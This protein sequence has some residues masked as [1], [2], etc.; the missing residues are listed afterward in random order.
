MP[1]SK[2]AWKIAAATLL[3]LCAGGFAAW[4]FTNPRISDERQIQNLVAKVEHGVETKSG[5]E[6]MECVAP[7]YQDSS[8]FDRLEVLKL[9][10]SWVRSPEQ[11][12]VVV[13]EYQIEVEGRNAI[14]HFDVQVEVQEGER[15]R[16]PL[17]MEFEVKFE[18][19]WRKLRRVWL[20]KAVEGPSLRAAPE[21]YL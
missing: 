15:F 14:G 19:Q 18:R 12:D 8:G 5:R 3:I 1:M 4:W 16:A 11:A 2:R 20:V 21:E 6:I 17:Q 9:V 13:G 10:T 7:D